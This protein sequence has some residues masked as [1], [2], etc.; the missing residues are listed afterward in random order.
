MH[1]VDVFVVCLGGLMDILV[2]ILVD[3]TVF[4]R[5]GGGQR[6]LEG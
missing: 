3:L 4:I 2:G 6:S 1:G 5:C